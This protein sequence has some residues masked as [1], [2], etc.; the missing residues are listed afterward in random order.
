MQLCWWTANHSSQSF[1]AGSSSTWEPGRQLPGKDLDSEKH[2]HHFNVPVTG[3]KENWTTSTWSFFKKHRPSESVKHRENQP[4]T[5][6]GET[7]HHLNLSNY[8]CCWNRRLQQELTPPLTWLQSR[9]GLPVLAGSGRI[10]SPRPAPTALGAAAPQCSPG[11]S[12]PAA[13][14]PDT[15]N[16]PARDQPPCS[17]PG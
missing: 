9:L 14:A 16:P 15:T 11:R 10:G 7:N 2:K 12:S 17:L 13:S 4:Q 1:S 8:G 3:L 5:H 6:P